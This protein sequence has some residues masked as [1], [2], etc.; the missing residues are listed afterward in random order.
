MILIHMVMVV[1]QDRSQTTDFE[2]LSLDV[3]GGSTCY[4]TTRAIDEKHLIGSFSLNTSNQSLIF[5]PFFVKVSFS[6]FFRFSLWCV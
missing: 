5:L 6:F 1:F 4:T 3:V 2:I